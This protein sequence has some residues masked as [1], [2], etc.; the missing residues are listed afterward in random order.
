MAKEIKIIEWTSLCCNAPVDT[1]GETTMF[2]VCSKCNKAC[3]VK[4]KI[5]TELDFDSWSL[6]ELFDYLHDKEA[7]EDHES[8]ENSDRVDLLK[9]CKEL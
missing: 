4:K 3:D 2:H 5:S 6:Q 7:L 8:P 1:M 9:R